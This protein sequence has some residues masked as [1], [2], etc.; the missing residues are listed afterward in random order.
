[1]RFSLSSRVILFVILI[2]FP[3]IALG[4]EMIR[5][6]AVSAEDGSPLFNARVTLRDSQSGRILAYTFSDASGFFVIRNGLGTLPLNLE[7]SLMGYAK[8][9]TLLEAYPKESIEVKLA[10]ERIEL[11]EVRVVAPRVAIKG[12]TLSYHTGGACERRRQK[13]RRYH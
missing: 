5:G 2:M 7:I 13:H 8:W 10:L 1:M 4:Q 3:I 9:S 11:N 12:D 6:K